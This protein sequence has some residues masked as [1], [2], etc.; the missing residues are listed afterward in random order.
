MIDQAVWLCGNI[1]G[2]NS[3][4][5][6][7]VLSRTGIVDALVRTISQNQIKS[8]EFIEVL[9]GCTTN[10]CRT[11]DDDQVVL[12]LEERTKLLQVATFALMN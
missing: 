12:K 2:T 8:R 6:Q 9:I 5:R 11:L 7:E 3:N 10:L 4:L 1:A